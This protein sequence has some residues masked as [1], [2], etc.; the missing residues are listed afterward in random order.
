MSIAER[1]DVVEF[2]NPITPEERPVL[3]A[4]WCNGGRLKS[5]PLLPGTNIWYIQ[6]FLGG[7]LRTLGKIKNKR[8]HAGIEKAARFADM[9]RVFFWKYK[10]MGSLEPQPGDLNISRNRAEKD[11]M[12]EVQM[13]QILEACETHLLEKKVIQPP[14]VA[15]QREN[16]TRAAAV[17]NIDLMAKLATLE[18]HGDV[19]FNELQQRLDKVV[20]LLSESRNEQKLIIQILQLIAAR[21]NS[22]APNADKGV[23]PE[24]KP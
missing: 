15:R 8:G 5:A 12:D 18:T 4:H 19:K 20:D 2:V 3:D 24:A 14:E 22:G 9:A 11:L 17:K 1:L 16:I 23:A 10:V 6:V 7:K 13:R 21:L